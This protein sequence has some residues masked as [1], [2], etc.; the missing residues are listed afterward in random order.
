MSILNLPPASGNIQIGPLY[1]PSGS[2]PYVNVGFAQLSLPGENF[3]Q[4]L[5]RQLC[6]QS[7]RFYTSFVI[8]NDFENVEASGIALQEQHGVF[9]S[10]TINERDSLIN[11][12]IVIATGL[13]A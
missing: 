2:V 11:N 13:N 8:Q 5:I 6:E 3:G 4:Y 1:I 7:I 12:L 10:N 9:A